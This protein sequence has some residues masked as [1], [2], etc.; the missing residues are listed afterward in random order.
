LGARE[1]RGVLVFCI[2]LGVFQQVTGINAVF[3]YLPIIF[4]KSAGNVVD[5]FWQTVVVGAVNVVMTL[6]AMHFISV[7]AMAPFDSRSR[8]GR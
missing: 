1:L 7:A 3:Y 6:V 8:G 2:G 5:A 4:T